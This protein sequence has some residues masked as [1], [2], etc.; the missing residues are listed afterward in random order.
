MDTSS[1][2]FKAALRDH[3]KSLGVDPD[4]ESHLMALVEE[5][6]LAEVPD[7]WEQGETEDGTLYYFNTETEESIWEHPLDAHYRELIRTK[8]QSAPD[9]V[10][11][12]A[13]ATQSRA[14]SGGSPV[15]S[16][17]PLSSVE[18]YS[19]DDDSD[20][21]VAPGLTATSTAAT[22]KNDSK[23]SRISALFSQPVSSSSGTTTGA[24]AAAQ[25]GVPGT[26]KSETSGGGG[27][28]RDRSWL[29]DGDED[30]V[31]A[32]SSL[33]KSAT[34]TAVS[35]V[36]TPTS[37]SSML[38]ADKSEK[39]SGKRSA[40]DSSF[41]TSKLSPTIAVAG[42][43]GGAGKSGT[44][45][46]STFAFTSRMYGPSTT[47]S[48]L[49]S[50]SANE[51]T[52]VGGSSGPSPRRGLGSSVKNQFFQELPSSSASTGGAFVRETPTINGLLPADVARIQLLEKK[53]GE[54]A[55]QN[56]QLASDLETARQQAE[57]AQVEAKES[58]YLKMKAS[59]SK[60]KLAEKDAE[61]QRLAVD[62][63]AVVAKLQREV[64]QVRT[65]EHERQQ[66]SVSS[67][68]GLVK[69]ALQ[70]E[71]S[72]LQQTLRAA[73]SETT[74]LQRQCTELAAK[75]AAL[76]A[77]LAQERHEHASDV[78]VLR[79]TAD[80]QRRD[81]DDERRQR[82][83]EQD[84]QLEQLRSQLEALRRETTDRERQSESLAGLQ[85]TLARQIK[86][87]TE[88]EA[89]RTELQ[90][91][92]ALADEKA[93]ARDRECSDAA[94]KHRLALTELDAK[95]KLVSTLSEK[96][97]LQVEQTASFEAKSVSRARQE[98]EF[99]RERAV[100]E[101]ERRELASEAKD[102][103][104]ELQRLQAQLR[105]Q[106]DEHRSTVARLQTELQD[107]QNQ[108][109][110]VRVT[111]LP[112][113]EKQCEQLRRE[114]ERLSER[115]AR[116]DKDQRQTKLALD[117]RTHELHQLELQVES[118]QR[119]ETQQKAQRE[120]CESER[121]AL[122]KRIADLD[123][124]AAIEK[125]VKRLES[126][127]LTIRAREL[128]SV[129]AQKEYEL[130]RV[131]EQFAKAEAWRLKEARRVDE[132]DAQLADAKDEL[133]QLKSR[134]VDAEN[135]AALQELR[136]ER[137]T[138]THRTAQL[139]QALDDE[140][141]ARHVSDQKFQDELA[142]VQKGLAWQLPQLAAACVNRASDEWG[143]KCQQ[144]AKKLR[145]DLTLQ[146]LTER[147]ALVSQVKHAQDAR[148]HVERKYKDA[149]GECEFLRK[150]VHRV[151]D[152]NKVLL[153]QLHTI[154]VYLTQRCVSSPFANPP[155]PAWG[156]SPPPPASGTTSTPSMPMAPMAPHEPP[157]PAFG[158]PP[159]TDF[160]T[161]NHLNVQLGVLHAQFQQLFDA[162]ERR[163]PGLVIPKPLDGHDSHQ[164]FSSSDRFEIPSSPP[165]AA[166]AKRQGTAR[167]PFDLDRT[168]D[169]LLD[170]STSSREAGADRSKEMEK[171]QLISTLEALALSPTR[172]TALAVEDPVA[173]GG[174]AWYQKDYW[175][176]KY[177]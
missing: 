88:A 114:N 156:A 102:K 153:D 97:R 41:G 84:A 85:D 140:K 166:R 159:F 10:D 44:A 27:F 9:A 112:P 139:T 87:L 164:G 119:R 109:K 57:H 111:E 32:L 90:A 174:S 126:E 62:H 77:T 50:V 31:A 172:T 12:G 100:A 61:L 70:G 29:L 138:L 137:E 83:Q 43:S 79:D 18:V 117:E 108:L 30:D 175:R 132:R 25:G 96:L 21:D 69:A 141:V 135:A 65:S 51:T 74:Q 157:P 76:D 142:M 14:A 149:V 5:A 66:A 78:A 131:N 72:E 128:E 7:G 104:E 22:T 60:A 146:A 16:S 49:T 145:D 6:L 48:S 19:F 11:V 118:W 81:H 177:Q 55:K 127:K 147:N 155:F 165:A 24:N 107:A 167:D 20:D 169:V 120:R 121:A 59:E 89:K 33:P 95:E 92:V 73:Q 134:H 40:D 23:S 82:R 162:T 170:E 106:T 71:V 34:A 1:A 99:K 46:P 39:K 67:Q 38:Q 125:H 110:A 136:R 154:R 143:R 94:A 130:V 152:N 116:E 63:A 133:A 91:R 103:A 2:E 176:S 45:A 36:P 37:V 42:S 168:V 163:P 52:S 56:E 148:E 124:E 26:G 101:R 68:D 105:K 122:E 15:V 160:S 53:A 123:A 173:T 4:A 75:A 171:E 28:G 64:E 158:W 151:E 161:I 58:H 113:L 80:Q 144:V 35:P 129:V 115:L 54:L 47:P 3:A 8:K 86:A 13:K 17:T 93:A 150:E 98:D